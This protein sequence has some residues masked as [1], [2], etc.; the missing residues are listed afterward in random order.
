MKSISPNKSHLLADTGM[1]GDAVFLSGFCLGL[2][3]ERRR[4]RQWGILEA[5]LGEEA[6]VIGERASAVEEWEW[7]RVGA[8]AAR[9]FSSLSD[10]FV[11]SNS[12]ANREKDK[13]SR[14]GLISTSSLKIWSYLNVVPRFKILYNKSLEI[15]YLSRSGPWLL[16]CY[17]SDEKREGRNHFG[18]WTKMRKMCRTWMK[19]YRCILVFPHHCSGGKKKTYR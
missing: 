17:M 15:K 2:N 5:N 10:L 18:I 9:H 14:M 6:A 11:L 7:E 4:M 1:P 3:G 19:N 12:T 8:T 13:A 16:L